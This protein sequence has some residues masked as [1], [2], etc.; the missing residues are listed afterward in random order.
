VVVASVIAPKTFGYLAGIVYLIAVAPYVLDIFRG[1]TKPNRAAYAIWS[2]VDVVLVTSYISAGAHTTIY[3]PIASTASSL[4]ILALAIKYGMGGASK[5]DLSCL[6]IAAV[7]IVLWIITNDP[8]VA[9]YSSVLA[10]LLGHLPVV[11]KSWLQPWT[12][13]TLSWGL[14]FIAASLNVAALTSLSP[15]LSLFPLVSVFFDT[16]IFLLLIIARSKKSK[17][18]TTVSE[19]EAVGS[20]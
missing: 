19:H 9:L 5:L 12:E 7:A 20:D 1:N 16:L 2:V 14:T 6:V 3:Y 17:A 11:K 13:N 18:K 8:V 4:L 15:H 10:Y